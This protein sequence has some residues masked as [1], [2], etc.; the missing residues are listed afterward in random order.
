MFSEKRSNAF[1]LYC[2]TTCSCQQFY[3][4]SNNEMYLGQPVKSLVLL[5][6]SEW[7]LDFLNRFSCK[8]PISKS[9][10]THPVG[11]ELLYMDRHDEANSHFLRICEHT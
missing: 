5:Y 11:A 3:V 8:Y 1:L 2:G 9:M 7:N 6:D 10:K 4:T